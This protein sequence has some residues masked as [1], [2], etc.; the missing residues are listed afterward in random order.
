MF[1]IKRHFKTLL[2]IVIALQLSVPL[3]MIVSNEVTLARGTLY[4]FRVAPVDPYDPF[5]GRYVTV[6]PLDTHVYS[7]LKLASGDTAY[8]LLKDSDGYAEI[9]DLSVDRPESSDYLPVRI[10]SVSDGPDGKLFRIEYP[11]DRIFMNE[12]TAPLVDRAFATYD[13]TVYLSV[14]VKDGRATV[15]NLYFDSVEAS[16]FVREKK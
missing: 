16:E 7:D 8:A 10:H 2:A 3:Y 11:F 9:S 15:R 6:R 13:G 1:N 12:K 5:R 4:R 14:A